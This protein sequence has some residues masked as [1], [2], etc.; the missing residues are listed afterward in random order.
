MQTALLICMENS[1][2]NISSDGNFFESFKESF[3]LYVESGMRKKMEAELD[4]L[5]KDEPDPVTDDMKAKFYRTIIEHYLRKFNCF[6]LRLTQD[7]T[8]FFV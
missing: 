4:I 7:L 8:I 1:F 3:I 5:L 6:N 2:W